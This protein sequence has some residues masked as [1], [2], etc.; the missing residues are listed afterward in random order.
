VQDL[1]ANTYETYNLNFH[2]IFFKCSAFFAHLPPLASAARCGPH[3]PHPRRYATVLYNRSYTTADIVV[4]VG[5][6]IVYS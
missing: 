5:S 2:V 4:D 6:V 1:H 3:P